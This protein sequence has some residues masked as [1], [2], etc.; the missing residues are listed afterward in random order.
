[1]SIPTVILALWVIFV[2]AVWAT[3]ITITP[4]NLGVLSVVVGIIVLVIEIL[5]YHGPWKRT[6]LN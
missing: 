3:W 1:M 6:I 5:N 2:G 4:H